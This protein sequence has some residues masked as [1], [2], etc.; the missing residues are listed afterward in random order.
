MFDGSKFFGKHKEMYHVNGTMQVYGN[1]V[2]VKGVRGNRQLVQMGKML[3]LCD[4]TCK[5]HMAVFSLNIGKRLQ[6]SPGCLFERN[7]H[8]RFKSLRVVSQ[9]FDMNLFTR[10]HINK[11]DEREMP[12]LRKEHVPSS[13]DV[14]VSNRGG[15][16]IRMSWK[17]IVWSDE[18][19]AD[20]TR[21]CN[22]FSTVLDECC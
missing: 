13:V 10:L 11:F 6:T 21:F 2:Q 18:I 15:V 22:W 20:T 5:V 8:E 17:N 16:L 3:G 9:M 19:E 7:I 12:M 1:R 4:T 14:R